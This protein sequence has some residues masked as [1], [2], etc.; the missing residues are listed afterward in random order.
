MSTQLDVDNVIQWTLDNF[1]ELEEILHD[2][3][4]HI[5]WL[6]ISAKDFWRKISPFEQ[7]FPKILFK[8]II[9]YHLDPETT[10]QNKLFLVSR[11][12]ST[13]ESCIID[14]HHLSRI[15][16][17]IEN[18]EKP[19]YC[20]RNT[21]Y[22]FKLLYRASRDGFEAKKFHELCDNK[23]PTIMISKLQSDGKL[24]G[25]YNPLTWEPYTTVKKCSRSWQSS[26]KSFLFSFS[27]KNIDSG[28]IMKIT[29]NS[30]EQ[31]YAVSYDKNS[32]PAFGRGWDLKITNNKLIRHSTCKTYPNIS[33]ALYHK[34]NILEDYEV[35]QVEN[36][37]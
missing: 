9:G 33:L 8:N 36:K 30:K 12:S 14:K 10:P 13:F 23:G 24:I 6:Q 5:R 25:S 29:T 22:L 31:N 4:P 27:D 16:S 18:K 21:P 28:R 20:S 3:I 19:I 34:D 26:S 2:L 1:I 17:W 11:D 35:F 15:A 7:M 37:Y 32:G